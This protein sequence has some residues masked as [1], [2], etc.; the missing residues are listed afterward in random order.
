[1]ATIFM[2]WLETSPKDYERGIQLITFGQMKRIRERIISEFVQPDL[3]VLDL[4]CGTGELTKLIA[5]KGSQVSAVDA[6]PLM[7]I[8]AG[9]K[10]KEFNLEE[11]VKFHHLDAAMIDDA[12]PP[13]SFDLIV[14]SMVFSSLQPEIQQYLLQS[15][16]GLLAT[17]G[18]VVIV[19]ETIPRNI[20]KRILYQTIRT[21]MLV[22]T[23]LLT[24]N[25]FSQPLEDTQK[26]FAECGYAARQ[27][28]SWWLD[29]LVLFEAVPQG[30]IA[31]R[32]KFI[33][34]LNHHPSIKTVLKDLVELFYRILP[35][36]PKTRPGLYAV[37][38]PDERSPVLITGNYDLTVRR[39][40][41][42]IDGRTN[43]WVLVVD[44][45][46][47]NVWCGAGAGFF[48][49]EKI[50]AAV[51]IS[52]LEKIVSHKTLILP[53][54]AATGVDGWKIRKATGWEVNWG[55]VRAEDIPAY[56]DA[57]KVKSEEMSKVRFPLLDRLE[58][59]VTVLSF[60][61][62][63]ILLPVLIFWRGIFWPVT[64]AMVCM[65][66]FYAIFLPYIPG[67]D[68]LQKAVP[69]TGLVLVGFY[70]YTLFAPPMEITAM[71]NWGLGLVGLAVFTT[72]ELQGTS[73]LMRGEQANW[74]AEGIIGTVLVLVYFLVPTILGWG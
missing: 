53:Q 24:R 52:R 11:L 38:E 20:L 69:F 60:Y 28:S 8:E 71:F 35:P 57:G 72:A 50:I 34:Q 47:I 41:S 51:K 43:A 70:V 64:I 17:G 6:A 62:L 56:L 36:Y 10:I 67:K 19:D 59:L 58:M 61:S 42:A 74:I 7:L 33:G 37:G 40:V 26:L 5:A 22:L 46:G 68:G 39:L 2:K 4:G 31:S 66:L 1:M 18:K 73:P 25:I 15:F 9:K 16:P 27:T 45:A 30:E 44:T 49:A 21:I 14:C 29:S 23:W 32:D 12:F 13:Q 65:G 55:P 63:M 3:K 54:L 48:S